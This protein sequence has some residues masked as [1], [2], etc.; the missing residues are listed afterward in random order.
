MGGGGGGGIK[1]VVRWTRRMEG[2]RS[3]RGCGAVVER[4]IFHFD[5]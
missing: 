1:V 3:H 5:F 4:H 2:C